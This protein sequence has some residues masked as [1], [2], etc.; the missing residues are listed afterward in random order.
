LRVINEDRI[1]PGQGFGVHPHREMGILTYPISGS[2]EHEDDMG[3]STVISASEVQRMTAGDGIQVSD[4][5]LLRI[6]AKS[7][8]EFLLFDMG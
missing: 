5:S 7:E 6:V 8:V 3:N 4:E 1:A 2:I